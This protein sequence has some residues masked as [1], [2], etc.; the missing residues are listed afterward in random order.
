LEEQ[1]H[2]LLDGG[3]RIAGGAVVTVQS[4]VQQ[5]EPIRRAMGMLKE[6]LGWL[7][8]AHRIRD[9]TQ[10]IV[11]AASCERS[12]VEKRLDDFGCFSGIEAGSVVAVPTARRGL[13]RA[14]GE[15]FSATLRHHRIDTARDRIAHQLR[16]S[17][18]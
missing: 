10:Y 15:R 14:G 8:C 18:R 3:D 1:A 7:A 4:P 13:D 12:G 17:S 9:P 5:P 2:C 16:Q 6:N 11:Q